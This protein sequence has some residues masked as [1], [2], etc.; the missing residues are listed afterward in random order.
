MYRCFR[1]ELTRLISVA[2]LATGSSA[3]GASDG[4]VVGTDATIA[5]ANEVDGI[6]GQLSTTSGVFSFET[7]RT[8]AGSGGSEI[9]VTFGSLAAESLDV[10]DPAEQDLVA[11][12]ALREALGASDLDGIPHEDIAAVTRAA[13]SI[14][15]G[16][17][18]VAGANLRKKCSPDNGAHIARFQMDATGS[19]DNWTLHGYWVK[20]VQNAGFA[21]GNHNDEKVFF[22]T[23]NG[24]YSWQ[25][26]DYAKVG[27]WTYRNKGETFCCGWDGMTIYAHFDKPNAGDPSCSVDFTF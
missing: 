8:P 19:G 16:S 9:N 10:E 3:C 25:S 26:P 4:Y 6:R 2:L 23:Q 7:I 17:V 11:L 15:A 14:I 24:E 5:V 21:M 13:E 1:N 18:V 22:A 12:E 20:Y 27:K